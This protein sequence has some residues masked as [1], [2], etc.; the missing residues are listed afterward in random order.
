MWHKPSMD[1][2]DVVQ[3]WCRWERL[4]FVL[5]AFLLCQ[6]SSHHDRSRLCSDK[7][8]FMPRG[9]R[10]HY[11]VSC[12]QQVLTKSMSH[13]A[14]LVKILDPIPHIITCVSTTTRTWIRNWCIINSAGTNIGSWWWTSWLSTP[15]PGI[16]LFFQGLSL[17]PSG[18]SFTW[19]VDTR[20]L[21]QQ[22]RMWNARRT[23][24]YVDFW[25]GRCE[26]KGFYKGGCQ[27]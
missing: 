18:H 27:S 9:R 13:S 7:G 20:K 5:T 22:M 11:I 3:A 1:F 8:T 19:Y 12:L 2:I 26:F 16:C 25:N 24:A 17:N 23:G 10:Q 4:H 21:A 14:N 15:P 6:L